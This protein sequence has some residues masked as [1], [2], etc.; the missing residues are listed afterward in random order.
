M[1]LHLHTD[2]VTGLLSRSGDG[3]MLEGRK[4]G[5]DNEQVQKLKIEIIMNIL[6]GG[7]KKH[8]LI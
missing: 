1:P 4:E 8:M 2:T 3:E 7:A 5:G 6:K